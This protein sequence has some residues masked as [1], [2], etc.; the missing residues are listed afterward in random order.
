MELRKMGEDAY[1]AA[2]NSEKGFFSYYRECFDAAHIKRVF[3]IKGGPG[4]GKSRFMREV[5]DAGRARG[6]RAEYIYCSSDADS[7]DGI[8]LHQGEDAVAL[9]DAT[10]P[11]VYEPSHPG[12]REELVNLGAF[13]DR[14]RLLEHADRIAILNR[15]KSDAYRRAYRYLGAEGQMQK[16]RDQLVAPYLKRRSIRAYAEKQLRDVPDGNEYC[17][18]PAL[19]RSVG[20]HGEVIFDTYFASAEKSVLLE[21]CY[22]SAEIFLAALGELA[23]KKKLQIR[24]S[25]DPVF[26]ER[27]DGIFFTES[28]RAFVTVPRSLEAG[29][30]RRVSL[31]RF[32]EVSSMKPIRGELLFTERMRKALREGALEALREVRTVH[33]QLEEC[34]ISAMDF[35]A[36]ESFTK[37]FCD[38]LF[39]LKK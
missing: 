30:G 13:W 32:V 3:A 37:K 31:R 8:I 17:A 18:R 12:V 27:L 15:Q 10:A 35:Q 9:L 6:W 14:S 4:T 24:V 7:L 1:F 28:R 29:A 26:P 22:G 21:D 36:K 2:S 38:S 34:Y 20:M 23:V 5:A 16:I 39:D 19:V 11:H 25:H 33:F